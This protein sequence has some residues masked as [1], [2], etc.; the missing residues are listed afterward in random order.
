MAAAFKL[1]LLLTRRP[2]LSSEEFVEAWLDLERH[3]PISATGLERYVVDVALPSAAPIRGASAAPYDAVVESWWARKNDAADFVVSRTF[4][5]DWMP[6]RR[7]LL[8]DRPA[9]VIGEPTVLWEREYAEGDDPV[10]VI[11]LPIARRGLGRAAF[12]E[13]W[14]GANA[15]LALAG[16]GA[17]DRVV[18]LEDTPAPLAPPTRF[19]RTNYDGVGAI[20]FRSATALAE[21]FSS[22]YYLDRVSPDEERFTNT[23]AS[24]VFVGRGVDLSR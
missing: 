16:P 20:V 15:A 6:P 19:A 22:T 10:T 1:T 8:A 23:L 17:Q 21:E 9:A 12:T 18:R 24:T 13:H 14:T 4:D 7:E 11:T 3:L 5:E 2:D